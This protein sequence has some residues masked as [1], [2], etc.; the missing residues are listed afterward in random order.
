[1]AYLEMKFTSNS[2]WNPRPTAVDAAGGEFRGVGASL[3]RKLCFSIAVVLGVITTNSNACFVCVVPHQSLLDRIESSQDVVI[4][5]AIDQKQA[6]WQ[7]SRVI[8]GERA[9]VDQIIETE[10]QFPVSGDSHLL[11]RVTPK[12]PKTVLAGRTGRSRPNR[13]TFTPV[14]SSPGIML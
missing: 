6:Q 5:H 11:R 8:R 12:D 2:H 14:A 3:L 13:W 1:M 9:I 10:S 4:A 7:V